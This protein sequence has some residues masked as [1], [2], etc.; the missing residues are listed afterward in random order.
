MQSINAINSVKV[1][2]NATV[3]K[4]K[5]RIIIDEYREM[6]S[7]KEEW[8]LCVE[9]NRYLR[10]TKHRDGVHMHY[11]LIVCVCCQSINAKHVEIK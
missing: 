2:M 6:M 7:K 10:N 1:Y 3:M 9:I 8:H 4:L 11:G 5:M